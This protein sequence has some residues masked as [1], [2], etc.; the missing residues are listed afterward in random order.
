MN[1]RTQILN[2][3][4][5]IAPVLI[6]APVSMPYH[7]PENYFQTFFAELSGKL[8]LDEND[9]LAPLLVEAS[10]E[11][12]YQVPAGYFEGLADIINDKIYRQEN[13]AALPQGYFESLPN[14]LLD[15]IRSIE[16]QQ[17][18]ENMAPLL[19]TI[20]KQPVNFV[21]EGYFENIKVAAP[22]AKEEGTKVVSIKR[23]SNWLKYAVAACFTGAIAFTAVNIIGKKTTAEITPPIAKNVSEELSKLPDATIENYLTEEQS[24]AESA[25]FA[26]QA[27]NDG[28]ITDF[29]KEVSDEDLQQYL[30]SEGQPLANN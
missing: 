24:L 21:P 12:V 5:S 9:A 30:K 13:E 28:E 1:N 7:T 15:K 3:L 23:K 10:K 27:V 29:L 19:N 4:E 18:L 20:N 8:G 14:L 6:N 2:E 17:E 22:L 26:Y 25:T 11:N 16:V